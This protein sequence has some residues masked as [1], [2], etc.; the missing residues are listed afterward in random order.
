M[1]VVMAL[2]FTVLPVA[3]PMREP[4]LVVLT[5]TAQWQV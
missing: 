1:V 5:F 2:A 4:E 3:G